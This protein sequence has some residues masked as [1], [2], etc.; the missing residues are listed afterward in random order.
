MALVSSA[1]ATDLIALATNGKVN[2]NSLGVK[3]LSDDEMK[4]VVGGATIL[5]HLYGNTYEY[6]IPY[7]YGIKNNSGTRVS[8]TAYYKL[9]ED[10]T[11]EL[12][13][14]NVDNGRGNYIPVVQATLSHLN[15]QVSVSIIGMNQHNPIY[16]RPADRYYAD[17]LLNDRKIFN[18]INGIIR[19]DA[20]K[21]WGIK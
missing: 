2:E 6:Y 17:K 10:Y 21:Y 1:Y 15:N 11:N 12:R 9:F 16:S 20:N 5:K 8:Y 18:E 14:L 13:P 7:H 19:N 3:V 4:K